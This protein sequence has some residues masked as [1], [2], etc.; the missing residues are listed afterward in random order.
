MQTFAAASSP[1]DILS[2]LARATQ[3]KEPERS[4]FIV[5]GLEMC[6]R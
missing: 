4:E 2:G 6:K 1:T 5:V 3:E